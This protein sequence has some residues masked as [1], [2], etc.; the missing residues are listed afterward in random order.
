L[1]GDKLVQTQVG[2]PHTTVITREVKDGTLVVVSKE[3]LPL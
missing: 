1:N 2:K 3:K